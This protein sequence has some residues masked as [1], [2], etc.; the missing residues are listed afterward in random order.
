M[1]DA[2]QG[3]RVVDL[4]RLLPGPYATMR[5]ADMGAEVIKVEDPRVGDPVRMLPFLFEAVNRNKK[6]V[7]LDIKTPEGKDRL[8]QLVKTADVLV[9][10]FRP[11][12]MKA[13]GLD[14]DAVRESKPD[15]I[16]CSLTGYGQHGPMANRAGHD[17]NYL[18]RTGVLANTGHFQG[19]PVLP[20]VTVADFGGG[21]IAV[22]RILAALWRRSRTGEGAYI[23]A[24][25]E[26]ILLSYQV[27]N[28][29]LFLAGLPTG[30]G[31]Q[32]LNGGIICYQVYETKDR[33][34]VALGA[35]EDKFWR[36]FCEGAECP[37]LYPQQ[38]AAAREGNPPFERMK[39]IFRSRTREEWEVFGKERDC[40]LT[41]VL[42]VGEMLDLYPEYFA[43]RDRGTAPR[44]GEHNEEVLGTL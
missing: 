16:Y 40:C 8:L 21:M 22:E 1:R 32:D 13:F 25:M 9:E 36:S 27:V 19:P 5:L 39:A 14:Y 20:G 4:S 35:L 24:N 41:A 7:T 43:F 38:R 44:L 37:D 11:G 31:V 10:S 28:R 18:A 23:D 42:E 30:R 17:I 29:A 6:S 2:L 26:E 34:Y 15:I 3:V 33:K 12:A